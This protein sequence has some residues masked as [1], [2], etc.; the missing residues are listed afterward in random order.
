MTQSTVTERE[1]YLRKSIQLKGAD[2]DVVRSRDSLSFRHAEDQEAEE[3]LA[4]QQAAW[5]GRP[6]KPKKKLISVP[7]YQQMPLSTAMISKLQLDLE[8]K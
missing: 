1:E 7:D 4:D 5:R 3:G 8:L 6:G 2:D